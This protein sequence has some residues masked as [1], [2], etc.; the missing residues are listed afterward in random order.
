[1]SGSGACLPHA[2]LVHAPLQFRLQSGGSR[3]KD[4]FLVCPK[5][6]AAAF[7]RRSDRITVKVKHLFAHCSNSGC[8]HVFKMELVFVHS[9]VEGNLDRPDLDLAVCPREEVA[10]VFP[11]DAPVDDSQTNMFE[12]DTG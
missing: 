9:L 1:M 7:I 6:D 8:G 11:P 2:P 4:P 10:H 12:P 5:C 3:A